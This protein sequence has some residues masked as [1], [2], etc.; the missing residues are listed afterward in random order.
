MIK[1]A[2]PFTWKYFFLFRKKE[3]SL[4]LSLIQNTRVFYYLIYIACFPKG[5][6]IAMPEMATENC[7]MWTQVVI[8]WDIKFVSRY[9]EYSSSWLVLG[10]FPNVAWLR[11]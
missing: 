11:R 10:C 7:L 2:F 6:V 9:K 3:I 4:L 5:K 1:F 8:K